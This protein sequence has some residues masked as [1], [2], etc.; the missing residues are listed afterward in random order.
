MP[1]GLEG[2]D[3]CK[4]VEKAQGGTRVPVEY[5]DD[6]FVDETDPDSKEIFDLISAATQRGVIVIEPAGN[7]GQNLG[8]T[9]VYGGMFDRQQRDSGA[10]MVGQGSM[11]GK[12]LKGSNYGNRVDVQALGEEVVTTGNG[13]LFPKK[14][15]LVSE[16]LYE[17]YLFTRKFSGTSSASAIVAGAAASLQS[18]WIEQGYSPL[19]PACMREILKEKGTPQDPKGDQLEHIGP[20][21]NLRKAI[22]EGLA[23]T[24][25]DQEPDLCDCDPTNPAV[26]HEA[27]EICDNIDNDCDGQIDNNCDSAPI[28]T[29][30]TATPSS[31]SVGG[32]STISVEASDPDGDPLTY[33]WSTTCGTLSGTAGPE[34]KI[35]TAPGAPDTCTVEV[36]VTDPIGAKPGGIRMEH[37]CR[38]L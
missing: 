24:D 20:R 21:L 16:P 17:D 38:L 13:D 4:C 5:G 29:S 36:V 9:S 26:Y 33:D 27:A 34:D 35:F 37:S 31:V 23:N 15:S 1:P 11:K 8:D 18:I 2:E 22:D 3:C 7:G 30:L 10:I 28:I 32:Q 25:N 12:R 6:E 19:L 14:T